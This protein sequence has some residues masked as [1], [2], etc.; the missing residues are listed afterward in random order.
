MRAAAS[1]SPEHF[2]NLQDQFF[3]KSAAARSLRHVFSHIVATVFILMS[4][5]AFEKVQPHCLFGFFNLCRLAET[6]DRP[7][8]NFTLHEDGLR[9]PEEPGPK[10]LRILRC[11]NQRCKETG[12]NSTP[13]A[14]LS[15]G[16]HDPIT[17]LSWDRS[18]Q[19]SARCL[20]Q[21]KTCWRSTGRRWRCAGSTTSS[22]W[23]SK[24]G[25]GKQL[26]ER[27]VRSA[28]TALFLWPPGNIRVLCRVK[29]VLKE[30]QHEEGHSVV[31]TT[32][33]NNES[34][35]SVLSKGKSRVFE[36]DKVF[37]PQA[38]QEEVP[39][40]AAGFLDVAEGQNRSAK[41]RLSPPSGLS[42]D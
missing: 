38:A 19:P 24:V 8:S 42:G 15:S 27:Q 26:S 23:S 31:V 20:R 10:L 9:Q 29:P 13:S 39:P 4:V 11:G 37:Q 17:C 21:T 16:R 34:C 12:A 30:D 3:S 22:W 2:Q 14:S 1:C 18:P 40:S 25:G 36:M 32:D 5:T 33:P 41:P 35:L 7:P 6:T 28:S